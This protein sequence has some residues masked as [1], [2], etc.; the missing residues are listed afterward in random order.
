MQTLEQETHRHM[1]RPARG[2]RPSD[3]LH[4]FSRRSLIL[5]IGAFIT[6]LT[7]VITSVADP[8]ALRERA[9]LTMVTVSAVVGL[10]AL[11]SLAVD[12]VAARRAGAASFWGGY[13]ACFD[14]LRGAQ[15]DAGSGNVIDLAARRPRRRTAP[16]ADAEPAL[17]AVPVARRHTFAFALFALLLVG[18]VVSTLWQ[19]RDTSRGGPP[20]GPFAAPSTTST[21]ALPTAAAPTATAAG[22]GAGGQSPHPSPSATPPSTAPGT[23]VA[24]DSPSTDPIGDGTYRVGVDIAAGAWST[25]G[26]INLTLGCWYRINGGATVKVP[27]SVGPATVRLRAGDVFA[28]GGCSPWSRSE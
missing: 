25:G 10:T 24:A 14:D 1:N 11:V 7:V 22:K 23:A 17:P 27:L 16:E 8:A 28:T 21:L 2:D 15:P 26:A 12:V 6:R 18:L 4:L 13:A 5:G 9:L 3:W 20:A 19:P